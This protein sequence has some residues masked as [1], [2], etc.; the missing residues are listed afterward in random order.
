MGVFLT[1]VTTAVDL[2]NALADGLSRDALGRRNGTAPSNTIG[3]QFWCIVGARESYAR[4]FDHGEWQGFSCSLTD[5]GSPEA[6]QAA[7]AAS[8]DQITDRIR[9][10][11]QALDDA[12]EAVLIDLLEHEVQHHGQLIRYFYANG[13]P[14]PPDFARRY[15][16]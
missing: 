10:A 2:T 4:A 13:L 15:A 12:R 9:I 8:R 3:G 1:R 7:L 14:F 16:L 6:V 11:S 5:T